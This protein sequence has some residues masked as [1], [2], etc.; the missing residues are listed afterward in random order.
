M[1]NKI[2]ITYKVL[3][4]KLWSISDEGVIKIGEARKA[5]ATRFK[6]QRSVVS[7]IFKELREAKLIGYENCRKMRVLVTMRDLT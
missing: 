1:V 4:R 6:M 3:L 5:L 2:P 7:A